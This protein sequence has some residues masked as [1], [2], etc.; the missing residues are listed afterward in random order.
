MLRFIKRAGFN[1]NH[2]STTILSELKELQKAEVCRLMEKYIET[3]LNVEKGIHMF[4]VLAT[5]IGRKEAF[6]KLGEIFAKK[7]V[8]LESNKIESNSFI[9]TVKKIR[10]KCHT[11]GISTIFHR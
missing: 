10:R 3:K 1:L 5:I 2:D 9:G 11:E 4:Q 8:S 6:N 7:L